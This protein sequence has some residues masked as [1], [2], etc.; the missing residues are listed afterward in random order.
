MKEKEKQLFKGYVK[1]KNV[2]LGH[3]CEPDKTVSVLKNGWLCTGDV[4]VIND[5]AFFKIKGRNDDLIIRSEMKLAGEFVCV[6]EIKQ[7]FLKILSSFQLPTRI[8]LVNKLSKN[9]SGKIGRRKL[10]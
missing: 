9:G 1:G 8:E 6:E 10:L 5:V 3:Y 7:I 2:M 4:A